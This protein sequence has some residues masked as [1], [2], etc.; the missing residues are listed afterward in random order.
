M[1][2]GRRSARRQAVF[3]LY[4]QDLLELSATDALKRGR[5]S[6]LEPYTQGVVLGVAEHGAEIDDLV[7][8][9]LEG[10]ELSRLGSL[11]RSILR[12]A[13][14]EL[15]YGTDVPEPVAIDQAV[16]SAKRF[17]SDE[18]GALINGVLGSLAASR[19][20]SAPVPAVQAEEN[21]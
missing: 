6:G 11:E 4:Q 15:L 5:A 18:A 13:A 1:S 10:W 17:C 20:D 14:F 8:R 19:R 12:V 21:A 7:E 3:I 16:E 2:S 9:H